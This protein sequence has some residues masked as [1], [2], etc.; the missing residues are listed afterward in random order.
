M[1]VPLSISSFDDK[2]TVYR[3]GSAEVLPLPFRPY[4]L[5]EK[6]KFPYDQGKIEKW[7][8]IPEDVEKEYT[9]LEF[10]SIK[11][12]ND[13]RGKI[14]ER[15]RYVLIN[16]Y[17]EQIFIS[18][19]DFL[20]KYP[21][22]HDIT[23]MYFDIEVA[24]KG[25]G[26]FPRPVSNPILCIGFSIWKYS[27][28]GKKK[29]VAHHICKGYNEK[30]DSDI[31]VIEEFFDAIEETNPDVIAGFN[32][33][34][35]DM[36]YLLERAEICKIDTSRM[37]RG[38]R[39]PSIKRNDV[40]IPGRIHFDIYTSNAGVIKDQT[41]FG[42]KSRG[43]KSMARW[44]KAKRTI[45]ENDNWVEKELQDIE[46]PGE[47]ED[48]LKLFKEDKERLYAYL[49]DDVYRT[50]CVGN[51]YMRNC[52]TLAEMM[53]VPLNNV[54]N[55]YSSFI[56]KLL[57]GRNME[58]NRL[59]NTE[60]NF[61]KYNPTNGSIETIGT[62]F[63]AALSLLFKDGYSPATWKLDFKSQYPSIIMTFGL[64]PDTTKLIALEPYTGKYNCKKEKE[65]TW[66]RLP[67]T[68]DKGKYKYDLIVRVE[69]KEGF[70][71][72]EIKQ[73]MSE[74][75]R[76]KDEMKTAPAEI[77]EA[78]NSQQIA[79]KVI[80]NSIFGIMGLKSTKYGDMIT[81]TM[82]TGLARWCLVRSMQH[83]RENVLNCDSVT[84]DTPVYVRN[85]ETKELDIL[86]IEDL[87]TSNDIRET[88][89]GNYEIYT[90]NGW[91][92]IKYTKKHEVEKDIYRVKIS[93]GYVDVT[94]D[95]SLFEA[96]KLKEISPKNIEIKKSRIETCNEISSE[97]KFNYG[98]SIENDNFCWLIGFF[99]AEG[100]AYEGWSNS[101]KQI[102]RQISLNGNDLNL[103]K[104]VEKIANEE[105]A[106]LALDIRI[107]KKPHKF[108]LHDTIKSSQ[109]YKVQG[110]YNKLIYDW[111][112]KFCYTKNKKTKKVPTFILN[113]TK[114]MKKKFIEGLMCGD[115]Y[116][117]KSK[118][119]QNNFVLDS[120]F[121][122]LAAGFRF[123]MNSIGEYTSCA[124]RFD[125][126][127]I[128]QYRK[129]FS[130]KNGR[131]RKI[132]RNLVSKK[133]VISNKEY[134]Y[135]I[136]TDNGTFV[137]SMGNI[138]LHN[139]DGYMVDIP[140][141]ADK[142]TAWL[143]DELVKKFGIKDNYMILELEGDG[144]AAYFY[145]PKNYVV[146]ENDGTYLI[147]GSSLKASKLSM[148]VDRAVSLGI[149]WIFNNKPS[150]EVI[151]EAFDLKNL[152]LENFVERVNLS[153]EPS[154]YDDKQDWRVYLAEQVKLKTG[155]VLGK[156][157]QISYIVTKETLP[158]KE[159]KEFQGRGKNYTY[160]GYVD[161]L[162]EI[163]REY[164]KELVS[165]AL[166]K[167]GIS[168]ERQI[169]VDI[170]DGN[171]CKKEPLVKGKIH[172]VEKEDI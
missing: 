158:F 83:V 26:F 40:Y 46:L 58:K 124:V 153:K 111:F 23:V 68:F 164:Y 3:N 141:D 12:L 96:E 43:L 28:D 95:H 100:S 81:A 76:I 8:K 55:M 85:K 20:L 75:V 105:L 10:K 70:L 134:V 112:A 92:D 53:Q 1:R 97:N 149:E 122:T 47:I 22:T 151:R 65:Y 79:I 66:Y 67:S 138:V 34:S 113:G 104:K 165:R 88:Y 146:L 54:I 131:Y 4:A 45:K 167:F 16:P 109:V 120:K 80:M 163:D 114:R 6:D 150:E 35:F 102:K 156:G 161:S 11:A 143:K 135:D 25:D 72:K 159:F 63:Q 5:I 147:H 39:K 19:K 170:F 157:D 129:R 2:L 31:D 60:T 160:I 51:V 13:F 94:E 145:R 44:Y 130:Y 107:Q 110:G 84:G 126:E 21:H 128:T 101:S 64:G 148:V 171:K 29:K 59:I 136:S 77:K 17:I 73:L 42:I 38:D 62:K 61:S 7:T 9:R 14:K 93:D 37:S 78:L 139:T 91:K 49:D 52:I 15:D 36:P 74:R 115:G 87:H 142:E 116:R 30:N 121:K 127:N 125:K 152:P 90:R 119:G 162:E 32:S 108:R 106:W 117:N 172:E 57:V 155:Q 168:K 18:Q 50:E 123:I 154:E 41:L 33:A 98:Y 166:E 71:T 118:S 169:V 56:P 89:V 103:M 99:T 48:L 27:E 140:I 132:D 137:S 82:I 24:T 86:P 133:Y 69:N 144:E